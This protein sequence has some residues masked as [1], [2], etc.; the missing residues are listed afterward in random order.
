MPDFDRAAGPL[1]SD[2]TEGQ[3]SSHTDDVEGPAV[4][5]IVVGNHDGALRGKK[6]P[7][8]DRRHQPIAPHRYDA[9][10]PSRGIRLQERSRTITLRPSLA[11]RAIRRL[12][13]LGR[14]WQVLQF[15]EHAGQP[16]GV[17]GT[18]GSEKQR[19]AR[20]PSAMAHE[21][22]SFFQIRISPAPPVLDRLPRAPEPLLPV[23]LLLEESQV[24][25]PGDSCKG[26]L[27]NFAVRPI[28]RE[29]PHSIE[30]PASHHDHHSRVP[31]RSRL[32]SAS[33]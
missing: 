28:L 18:S 5:T 10:L 8:V 3:T 7:L 24:V 4:P 25:P 1:P 11:F 2:L 29:D 23:I 26:S 13:A 6:R 22:V 12:H 15:L 16:R 14:I 32:A 33:M 20:E 30:V 9:S 21:S 31:P 17:R 19:K 27:H